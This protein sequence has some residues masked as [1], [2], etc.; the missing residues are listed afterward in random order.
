[1]RGA[2]GALGARRAGDGCG[3]MRWIARRACAAGSALSRDI[4]RR[5]GR[6]RRPRYAAFARGAG[7]SRT[8]R[9]A[10]HARS[11][12]RRAR[13]A[14]LA[15]CSCRTRP[16]RARVVRSVRA[17]TGMV[18]RRVRRTARR[19]HQRD[20]GHCSSARAGLR[21]EGRGAASRRGERGVRRSTLHRDVGTR[22]HLRSALTAQRDA[23]TALASRSRA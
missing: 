13:S 11:A 10:A 2:T 1:M 3:S 19:D 12:A 21:E 18:R 15:R 8:D 17:G 22:G 4:A 5:G 20:V 7:G 23:L 16:V 9:R 14:A 6:Q